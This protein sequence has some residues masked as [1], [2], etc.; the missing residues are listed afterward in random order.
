VIVNSYWRR[1]AQP[2]VE[3]ASYPSKAVRSSGAGTGQS[4]TVRSYRKGILSRVEAWQNLP[5]RKPK[6]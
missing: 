2:V 3:F 1:G 5:L 6:K 4:P